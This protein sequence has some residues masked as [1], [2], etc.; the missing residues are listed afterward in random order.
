MG[1]VGF[2]NPRVRPDRTKR[3]DRRSGIYSLMPEHCLTTNISTSGRIAMLAAVKSWAT[4][5]V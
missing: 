4:F 1:P 3:Q 5:T 2:G